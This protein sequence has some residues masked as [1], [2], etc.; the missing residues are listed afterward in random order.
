L[1]NIWIIGCGDIGRRVFKRIEA[2]YQNHEHRTSAFVRSQ[3]SEYICQQLGINTL[4]YDLDKPTTIDQSKFNDAEIFYFAPPPKTGD[5][6]PRLS[7]FLKELGE[8]PA[9]IVLIST[10]GV[11]GDCNGDWM[12]E[13]RPINPQTDRAKRRVAAE[14]TLQKWASHYQKP[15][16]ILR[17]PGI[18]SLDR[19]PLKRLEKKL[20]VVQPSEAA[21]TNRIH[22]DDLANICIKAMDSSFTQ[23]IFNTTDGNPSTM[24]DYFNQIADYAELERPQQISLKDAQQ[25][26]SAGMLSYAGE[27]RR[28]GNAKLLNILGIKLKYPTLK[29][30]LK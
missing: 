1:K 21:F 22:A 2:L 17:V 3:E 4:L 13:T 9:K 18:Y 14:K 20:P 10:T 12:D 6:D 16:I 23:E 5:T 25:S 27:S 30:T 19:L 8:A 28:I 7:N 26:L 11:Y 24:V 15:Y 29:S